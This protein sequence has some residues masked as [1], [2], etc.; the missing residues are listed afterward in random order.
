VVGPGLPFTF[1]MGFTNASQVT[2][3]HVI[4]TGLGSANATLGPGGIYTATI[5][6]SSLDLGPIYVGYAPVL[7]PGGFPLPPPNGNGTILL[8]TKQQ[9]QSGLGQDYNATTSVLYSNSTVESEKIVLP[10]GLTILSNVTV[11]RNLVYTPNSSELALAQSIGYPIYNFTYS[12]SNVTSAETLVQYGFFI[13][14]SALPAGV[15]SSLLPPSLSPAGTSSVLAP[16]GGSGIWLRGSAETICEVIGCHHSIPGFGGALGGLGIYALLHENG[17]FLSELTAAHSPSCTPADGDEYNSE[18]NAL[19]THYTALQITLATILSIGVAAAL[20]GVASP[21]GL[22]ALAAVPAL[23]IAMQAEKNQLESLSEE[24]GCDSPDG[25]PSYVFDPSGYVYAAVS[26]NRLAN[27]T[28]SVFYR[29]NAT[30]SWTLWDAASYGQQ[31]Q[32]LTGPQGD[33]GWDVPGGQWMVV[34]QKAGYQSVDSPVLN[35]PPPVTDLD[36][37]MVSLA[38]PSVVAD[39]AVANGTSSRIT[40]EFNE[41]VPVGDLG[42]DTVFVTQAGSTTNVSGTVTPLDPQASPDGTLMTRAAVFTLSQ[43][44]STGSQYT[45]HVSRLIES[46]A[47]VSMTG[48]YASTLTA[49]SVPTYTVTTGQ[50]KENITLGQDVVARAT[51]TDPLPTVANFTWYGPDGKPWNSEVVNVTSGSAQSSFE[52]DQNGTWRVTA[53][54]TDG[55]DVFGTATQSFSV[56]SPGA[57]TGSTTTTTSSTSSTQSTTLGSSTT[58][59]SAS[60]STSS[61]S[62]GRSSSQTSSATSRASSTSL[63]LSYLAIL[64]INLLVVSLALLALGRREKP[65]HL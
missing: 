7:F 47:N 11:E 18:L 24:A 60:Q 46:Y 6:G 22:L 36:I 56:E 30:A 65:V 44:V 59:Q 58:T 64:A 9:I 13:P 8:P 62:S 3:V 29:P 17:E 45:V 28:A 54:F 10:D 52:P 55:N 37:G 49:Q 51:T 23:E 38:P 4:M 16:R 20:S 26:S 50:Q 41:Y 43:A 31:N 63:S 32:Q 5:S 15:A 57:Q 1:E 27:V 25:E 48:D 12:Y 14:D 34:Y 40:V 39:S 2:D 19:D 33:Y 42:S 21:L 61:V 35:V 53:Q